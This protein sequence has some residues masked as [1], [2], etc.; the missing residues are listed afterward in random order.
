MSS[1]VGTF[2][3][4]NREIFLRYWKGVDYAP[5]FGFR[6]FPPY[7]TGMKRSMLKSKIHRAT[8]THA[9]VNYEGSLTLDPQLLDAADIL[10]HEE[11]H[12]WNVTRGTRL[13][14]YAITGEDNSGVLCANGAAAHLVKPGDLVIISTFAMLDEHECREY[15]PKIVFVDERNQI[16]AA[17][18]GRWEEIPG[19]NTVAT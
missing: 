8:V 16:R 6:D 17:E 5:F 19:P 18:D 7:N 3:S 1:M 12:I 10:P 2:I 9:D 13:S 4:L 11:V 14:T 15:Q